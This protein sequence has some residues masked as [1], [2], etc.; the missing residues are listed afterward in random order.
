MS[1]WQETVAVDCSVTVRGPSGVLM[2]V[3]LSL[4]SL[5]SPPV[6]SGAV[7]L[8]RALHQ[9]KCQDLFFCTCNRGEVKKS[10]GENKN[11]S[12]GL[13]GWMW[14]RDWG[15]EKRKFSFLAEYVAFA[16]CH[17]LGRKLPLV[18]FPDG[19]F[20]PERLRGSSWAMEREKKILAFFFPSP[21]QFSRSITQ[22]AGRARALCQSLR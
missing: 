14:S 10:A 13:W 1:T 18:C 17:D 6:C 16:I 11:K 3:S 2:C 8:N 12:E 22:T 7:I 20:V 15:E 9:H 21:M 4:F 19:N 5:L